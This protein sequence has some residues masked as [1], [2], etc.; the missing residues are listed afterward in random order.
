VLPFFWAQVEWER[1]QQGARVES[2]RDP[3]LS[4]LVL[5]FPTSPAPLHRP[6]FFHLVSLLY[7]MHAT[8]D[9]QRMVWGLGPRRQ[10]NA[11]GFGT[12]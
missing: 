7:S 12:F 4:F 10:E 6:P 1:I 3:S 11:N 5:V 8:Q 2:I 9:V